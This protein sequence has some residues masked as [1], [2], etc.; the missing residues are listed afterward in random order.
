M[1]CA[2]AGM[3]AR[4]TGTAANLR[5]PTGSQIEQLLR[6]RRTIVAE[7]HVSTACAPPPQEAWL[8]QAHEESGWKES[9]CATPQEGAPQSYARLISRGA[10]FRGSAVWCA[11]RSTMWCIA[12]GAAGRAASLLSFYVPMASKSAGLAGA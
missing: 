3:C 4:E 6:Q 10:I 9:P 1:R 2:C 7:T 8:P 12:K 5:R 11:A